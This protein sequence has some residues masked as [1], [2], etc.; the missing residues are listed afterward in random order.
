MDSLTVPAHD[1][2][3][4]VPASNIG[5]SSTVTSALLTEANLERLKPS[6][7]WAG[8]RSDVYVVPFDLEVASMLPKRVSEIPSPIQ[9][10]SQKENNEPWP[11]NVFFDWAWGARIAGHFG[12][13]NAYGYAEKSGYAM[14]LRNRS[15]RRHDEIV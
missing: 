6:P 8:V 12:T 1:V 3:F 10:P 14:Y 11:Y 2:N 7:S 15:K 9:K 13:K 4:N 5:P